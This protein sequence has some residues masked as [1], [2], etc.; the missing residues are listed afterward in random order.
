[1]PRSLAELRTYVTESA[2]RVIVLAGLL[3]LIGS[4]VLRV[5][6]SML[7]FVRHRDWIYVALTCLVL[8]LLSVSFWIGMAK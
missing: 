6:V 8:V 7:L 2:G 3:V 4:P 1:M 5:T